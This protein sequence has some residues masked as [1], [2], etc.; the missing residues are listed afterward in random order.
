M[1]KNVNRKHTFWLIYEGQNN[2]EKSSFF[3]IC[4]HS[5]CFETPVDYLYTK[6]LVAPYSSPDKCKYMKHFNLME[7]N[8][9]WTLFQ[10]KNLSLNGH[11]SM[12]FSVGFI[13]KYGNIHITNTYISIIRVLTY[14]LCTTKT[15]W[16]RCLIVAEHLWNTTLK[17]LAIFSYSFLH[18]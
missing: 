12:F 3:V 11:E 9:C 4:V 13:F 2:F 10:E 15:N 8:L 16:I 17:S 1:H 14:T 18:Y 7:W 5:C 6:F